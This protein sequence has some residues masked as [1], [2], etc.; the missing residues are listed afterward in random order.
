MAELGSRRLLY[1]L[2]M[3]IKPVLPAAFLCIVFILSG[4]DSLPGFLKSEV[5]QPALSATTGRGGVQEIAIGYATHGSWYDMYFTDPLNPASRTYIGGVDLAVVQSLDRAHVSIH[6]ALYSLDLEDVV[7]ALLRAHQR[8]VQVQ[9]V[10][11]TDALDGNG[12][13]QLLA[14]GVPVIG[15]HRGALMHDKF[16]IVDSAVVW[17]G[18]MNMTNSSAYRDNNNYILL[19]DRDI[20][21]DY[22]SEFGEMFGLQRFGTKKQTDLSHPIEQ[23]PGGSVEVF[24]SPGGGVEHRVL[25]LLGGA[26]QSVYVLAY[27]FTSDSIREALVSAHNRGVAV[28]V[29]MDKDQSSNN[30]GTELEAL[31]A[32][33]ISVLLDGNRG[34]MH[35]KV[36]IIDGSTTILGSY[37]WTAAAE[38]TNDENL[39]VVHEPA[40]SAAFIQEF[41]RIFAMSSP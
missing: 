33:G 38:H 23:V 19:Q 25:E 11:E 8:G 21:A 14:A 1:S 20:A 3:G 30:Q 36:L 12:P 9:L 16:V 40:F 26:R 5:A 24:F 41:K 29:V 34:R 4:C 31:R 35:H 7:A 39:L 18:S 28:S 10:M 37:N 2:D 22:E 32:A 15:D 13:R 27:S 17:T 6:A